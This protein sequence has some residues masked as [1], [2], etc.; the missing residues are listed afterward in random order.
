MKKIIVGT[1]VSVLALMAQDP[2]V[3]DAEH[4]ILKSQNADKWAKADVGV[5]KKLAD[6]KKKFGTRPNIIYILWDDQ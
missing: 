3:H 5:S 6:L 4:Y 2:I 1:V